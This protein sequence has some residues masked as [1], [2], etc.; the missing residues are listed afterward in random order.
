M[1]VWV[2]AGVV[3]AFAA[4]GPLQHV[5]AIPQTAVGDASKAAIKSVLSFGA[6]E[7]YACFPGRGRGPQGNN[8]FGNGAGDGVPGNSGFGDGDR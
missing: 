8:G 6:K 5:G 7:A 2:L 1:K 4:A 3:G